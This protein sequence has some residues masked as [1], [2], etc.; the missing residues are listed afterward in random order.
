MVDETVTR[1]LQEKARAKAREMARNGTLFPDNPGI[2][3]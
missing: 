3:P 2:T 1:L